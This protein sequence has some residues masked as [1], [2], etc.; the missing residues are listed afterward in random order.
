MFFSYHLFL[1]QGGGC[2]I[3]SCFLSCFV[4][5]FVCRCSSLNLL[6]HHHSTLYFSPQVVFGLFCPFFFLPRIFVCRW[7]FLYLAFCFCLNLYI[8]VQMTV[9]LFCLLFM[10]NFAFLSLGG[11]CF[12]LSFVFSSGHATLEAALSVS[13]SVGNQNK[14][15]V[16]SLFRSCPPVRDWGGVYTGLFTYPVYLS[17]GISCFILSFVFVSPFNLISR[18]WLP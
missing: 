14:M 10:S 18:W 12:I 15:S 13:Q 2:F 16:F 8:C 7:W 9:V 4:C 17:A 6:F 5:F 11:G 1:F 3:L